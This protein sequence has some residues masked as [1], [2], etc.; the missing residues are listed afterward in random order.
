MNVWYG[1]QQMTGF[2]IAKQQT[3]VAHY[4]MSKTKAPRY[5]HWFQYTNEGVW[6][7]QDE[8][9][10]SNGDAFL[11]P[12]NG[13]FITFTIKLATAQAEQQWK[14]AFKVKMSQRN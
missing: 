6:L 13:R 1:F 11:P 5:E 4:D 10:P 12:P 8:P 2:V 14:H 7:D 3:Q 9:L